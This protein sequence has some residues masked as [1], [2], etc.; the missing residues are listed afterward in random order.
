MNQTPNPDLIIRWEIVTSNEEKS[1]SDVLNMCNPLARKEPSTYQICADIDIFD[2]VMILDFADVIMAVVALCPQHQFMMDSANAERMW[3]Y[4]SR[5]NM[6]AKI[7]ECI[8]AFWYLGYCKKEQIY[9]F[10]LPLTNLAVGVSCSTQAEVN[11]RIPYLLKCPAKMRYVRCEPLLDRVDLQNVT[12]KPYEGW[13]YAYIDVLLGRRWDYF[14]SVGFIDSST[15][16]IDWVIAGGESGR[17]ARPTDPDWV[18]SLRDQCKE[19]GTA[20]FF[21]QWGE[22]LP[23]ASADEAD[24]YPNAKMIELENGLRCCKVGKAVSGRLLDGVEHNEMPKT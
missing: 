7:Q 8:A 13:E 21:K 3:K 22:W 10:K 16:K 2:A 6:A 19:A 1:V 9:D 15:E 23:L 14:Q 18:R 4:F 5:T 12:V 20:F 24:N 17:G 11:E